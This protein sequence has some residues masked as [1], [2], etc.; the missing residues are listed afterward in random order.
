MTADNIRKLAWQWISSMSSIIYTFYYPNVIIYHTHFFICKFSYDYNNIINEMK[1]RQEAVKLNYSF[2]HKQSIWGESTT[3]SWWVMTNENSWEISQVVPE[4]GFWVW[5][6]SGFI[7]VTPRPA[8]GTGR[9]LTKEFWEE[10]LRSACH[11]ACWGPRVSPDK[12]LLYR[13]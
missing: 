9:N 2:Y 12:V 8:P 7:R 1:R 10:V 13:I 6:S 11:L 4:S 5:A 3:V